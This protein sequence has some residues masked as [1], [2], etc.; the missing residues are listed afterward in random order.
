MSGHAHPSH[1]HTA[2]F[3]RQNFLAGVVGAAGALFLP[4]A[5]R[6]WAADRSE[7]LIG[8][9][10]SQSGRFQAIVKP[11][12]KL[13]EAWAKRVNARGGIPLKSLGT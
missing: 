9:T 1:G 3:S 2:I 6:V 7:I 5:K 8:G 12:T 13:A 10:M 4:H 11:F